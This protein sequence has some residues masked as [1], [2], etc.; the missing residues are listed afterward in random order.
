MVDIRQCGTEEDR[1]A[2]ARLMAELAAWDS[3]E[4]E[5]L[6]FRAEDVLDFY[7]S[8]DD[9]AL[10]GILPPSGSTLL[11][12]AG[13]EAVGC[14]A[15]RHIQP[16]ICEMKR[17]YVRPDFRQSGFGGALISAL[18]EKARQAGYKVMR[19]ETVQFM[20]GAIHLYESVGF[21]RCPPY[22]DIPDIFRP[23]TIFMDKD[24]RSEHSLAAA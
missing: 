13:S 21:R 1:A 2:A 8:S 19:L 15:F 17:L 22:Y 24:L 6:G 23:I 11:G 4:T 7:Y 18:I 9:D 16:D 20:S 10:N 5:K 3:A 14:I 12:Y